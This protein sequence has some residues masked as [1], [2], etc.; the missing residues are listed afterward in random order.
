MRAPCEWKVEED[1]GRFFVRGL[2]APWGDPDTLLLYRYS[3]EESETPDVGAPSGH[4]R[5]HG[6]LYDLYQ[7]ADG[8]QDG[9]TF[10]T[11]FG[12]FL[13]AGVHVVPEGD[14]S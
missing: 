5:M 3:S 11:P 4:D 1:A 9:D 6:A 2:P 13:C 14:R 8:L 7:R 12:R 10:D